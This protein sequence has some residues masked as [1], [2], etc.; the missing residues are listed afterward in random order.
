MANN[1]QSRLRQPSG[2]NVN[3]GRMTP[4]QS[5]MHNRNQVEATRNTQN[6]FFMTQLDYGMMGATANHTPGKSMPGP[7]SVA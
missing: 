4:R 7:R 6:S 1:S 3:S 5:G 2:L